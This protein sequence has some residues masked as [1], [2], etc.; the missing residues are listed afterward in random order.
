MRSKL[1]VLFFSIFLLALLSCDVDTGLKPTQSG[2]SGVIYFQNEWPDVTDE[3]RVVA[4]T[5]FPPSSLEEIIMSEPLP[6]FVDSASFVIWTNPESFQAVGVVWKEKDQPW[7]VTNIIGIYFPTNDHFSPGSVRIPDKNTIIDS[8][9]I[10]ADLSA[11]RKHVNSAIQ[12]MLRVK[13]EWPDGA[14]SVLVVASKTVLPTSLL[15]IVFGSPI[16]A[17]FDSLSYAISVQ[18]ATYRLLGALVT[19]SGKSIGIESIKG[20]YRKRPSDFL[21]GSVAVPTDTTIISNI[22]ITLDFES[23]L[24]P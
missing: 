6:I 18:P 8:I 4:A 21:P 13:G 17:G 9:N 14:E 23:G 16:K 1:K 19:E 10:D 12:G 20:I 11:A 3:V 2:I 7:D 5:K 24:L 15:D 22:D